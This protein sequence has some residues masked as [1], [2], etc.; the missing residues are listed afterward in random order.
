MESIISFETL[1]TVY[2]ATRYYIA[3]GSGL[4][5]GINCNI[6][7]ILEM[8]ARVRVKLVPAVAYLKIS[9]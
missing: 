7:L 1:V 2:Q 9:V 5:N 8:L 4:K 3:E 6:Y